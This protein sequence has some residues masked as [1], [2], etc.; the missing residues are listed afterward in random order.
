MEFHL[1]YEGRLRANGDLKEKHSLRQCFHK[2]LRALWQQ[3]P[4]AGRDELLADPAPPGT[5]SVIRRVGE[6]KFA[7]LVC[8]ALSLICEL[9]VLFLR[10]EPPG[11]VVTQGGDIDNRLKTLFDGLRM[12][13]L[14]SEIPP[15]ENPQGDE[16][17]F[18]C[19]LEDDNLITRVNVATDRLLRTAV[20]PNAVVLVIR[21]RTKAVKTTWANTGLA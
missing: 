14:Q 6:Y 12:A 11:A 2:Q 4:L 15:G 19:L 16:T 13:R 5:G 3:V 9:D 10:P 18:F 1:L 8:E 20:E 21:A 17:P 7:P